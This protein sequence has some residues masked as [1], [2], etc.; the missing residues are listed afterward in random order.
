M[1]QDKFFKQMLF[2]TSYLSKIGGKQYN[3]SHKNINI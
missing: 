2:L 3:G 1:Y